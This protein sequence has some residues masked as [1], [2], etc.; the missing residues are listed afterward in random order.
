MQKIGFDE[1][2]STIRGLSG[3]KTL[4]TFHSVA[5]TDCIASAFGLSLVMK[6][7]EM[8][9]PDIVI[10][11]ARR[12][13]SAFGFNPDSVATAFDDTVDAVIMVDVNNFDDCGQFSQKLRDYKGK[14]V[15]IDHHVQSSIPANNVFVY[16]EEGYNSAT[17]IV[18][19]I[20]DRMGVKPDTGLARL[21]AAGI[22]SDSAEL[23]NASGTTFSQLG[24]LFKTGN[25]DY[26]TLVANI[27]HISDPEARKETMK[28]IQG[29]TVEIVSGL[30]FVHGMAHAHANIAA[31][32]AIKIG[33]DVSLF[34]A[35]NEREVSFS[36][37]LRPPLDKQLNI[38]LGQILKRLAPLI[39]GTGGGHPCAAGAYGPLKGQAYDFAERFI[40]EVTSR[41]ASL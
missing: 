28:D 21:L 10:A 27:T 26:T 19:D 24:E 38:H 6:G 22:V 36:A 31:D 16:N 12:T 13:L 2:V 39:S 8:A 20:L 40:E 23:R 14:I 4:I 32:H 29:A 37:R 34:S 3:G 18:Y 33:A 30:L 35:E 41:V 9:T 5:D 15:I 11:N 17:S 1:L 7:A 25:I